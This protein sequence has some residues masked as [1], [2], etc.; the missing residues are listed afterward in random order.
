[1]EH[2]GKHFIAIIGGSVAGSEAAYLLAERGY[3]AVVFDQK[4]LPYGKIEDGLPKWHVGLR[5]KEEGAIDKRLNHEN[6]RFV[7]EFTL[8]KDARLED[9]LDEWGFSAVIVAIGA[10]HD[11]KI[12]VEGIEKFYNNGVIKQN[13]LVYWFNHKHEPDYSG[14]KFKIVNNTAIVG[15][16]LAS[17]D[18]VKIVM[19]ELVKEALKKVK[20]IDVDIFTLEKK[21]LATV[22]EENNTSLAALG[23]EPCTLFYRRDAEDMPLYPRKTNTPEGAAQARRVSR[24][25]LDNYRAKYMFN[26][27]PR[28]V[29]KAIIE[30]DGKFKG[31]SFQRVDIVD[32]KLVDKAGD[33]YEFKTDLLVSSIGSLPKETPSLPIAGNILRTHGEYGC[34][35]EGFDNVFAVGNVVTGRGNILESRKHGRQTTDRIIDEHLEP[36]SQRD[37]MADKYED[38]FRNIEDDVIKKINNV[39]TTLSNTHIP[40]NDKIELILQKTKELQER[41]GYDGKYMAWVEA[42][43]PVRLEKM[44]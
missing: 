43:K 31:M 12:A 19:I 6:I 2:Y 41:A 44:S 29:P 18:M 1:M 7:P 16:G 15:G 37:P 11:R 39:S 8:G 28:S 23:V 30:E 5:D 32:G 3:R 9:L 34:R 20:N 24:K 25:L 21:G 35:I 33:V 13:D 4:K 26:F 22:L 14:P 36:M 10:W 17:L 42:Q 38:L 40:G 27:E